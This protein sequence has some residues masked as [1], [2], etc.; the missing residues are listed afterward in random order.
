MLGN[1]LDILRLALGQSS[2]VALVA[3]TDINGGTLREK[4]AL[5]AVTEAHVFGYISAGCVDGDIIYQARQALTDNQPRHLVYGEGSP[6]KDIALP[7]GGTIKVSIFPTPDTASMMQVLKATEQRQPARFRL[8]DFDHIYNPKISLR[9]VGRGAPFRALADIARA[10]GFLIHGQSPDDD[11]DPA[12][13]DRF[14]H[15]KDPSQVPECHTDPWS[16][17]VFLFHDHDW[18]PALLQQALAGESFYIGAMGSVR[19]HALR[20]ATLKKMGAE[21]IDR[22]RGPIGLIPAMRD[23]NRLALSILAEIIAAVQQQGRLS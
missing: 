4:G 2:P 21:N 14:E 5:M 18:E 16:A 19:T 9:I 17:V 7:C 8:G 1:P 11:I 13:F 20:L 12:I 10:S 6:F 22:I 23:A 15:L 3:V